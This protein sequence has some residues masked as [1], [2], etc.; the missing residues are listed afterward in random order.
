MSRRWEDVLDWATLTRDRAVMWCVWIAS[1]R[2]K[3]DAT[4][5]K[6]AVSGSVAKS[7]RPE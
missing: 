4:A 6:E 1:V 5:E 7:V 3:M 2:M